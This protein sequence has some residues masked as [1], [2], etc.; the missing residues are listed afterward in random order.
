MIRGARVL[1]SRNC[2]ILMR[3]EVKTDG[4]PLRPPERFQT[5]WNHV[6]DKESL[7]IKMLEQALIEKVCLLFRNLL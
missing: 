2:H 6:I 1:L 7:N 5:I 4:A 3:I